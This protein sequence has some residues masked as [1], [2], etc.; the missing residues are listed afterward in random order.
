MKKK[1]STVLFSIGDWFYDLAEHISPPCEIDEEYRAELSK[2]Y[3]DLNQETEKD[4][5][6]NQLTKKYFD[7]NQ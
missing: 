3:F 4:F 1:L 6:L 5:D 7:L 2:Q